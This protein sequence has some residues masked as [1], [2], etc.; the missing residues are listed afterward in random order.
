MFSVY[1]ARAL[2]SAGGPAPSFQRSP[3]TLGVFFLM[4]SYYVA[5]Y[6]GELRKARTMGAA[7]PAA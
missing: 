5:F 4:A 1:E 7:E 2:T 3:L 6:A